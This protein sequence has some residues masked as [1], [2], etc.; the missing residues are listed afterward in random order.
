[1]IEIHA[2]ALIILL[3][4]VLIVLITLGFCVY[5]VIERKDEQ[6]RSLQISLESCHEFKARAYSDHAKDAAAWSVVRS[7]I[8]EQLK[9]ALALIEEMH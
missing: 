7:S 9:A 6:I 8:S 5:A 1:M 4:V 2:L 3:L